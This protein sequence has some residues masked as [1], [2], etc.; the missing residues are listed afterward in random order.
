M[1]SKTLEKE[2]IL[3]KELENKTASNCLE[4]TDKEYDQS[5]NNDDVLRNQTY[6]L[7]HFVAPEEKYDAGESDKYE[8]FEGRHIAAPGNLRMSEKECHKYFRNIFRGETLKF[9]SDYLDERAEEFMKLY[10][11]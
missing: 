8:K 3:R 7:R 2:P 9:Y 6:F 5:C 11:L 1:K 10:G 4:S